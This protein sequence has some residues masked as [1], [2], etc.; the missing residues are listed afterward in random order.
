MSG[1]RQNGQARL[2][3]AL[4]GSTI[5]TM[6]FGCT[7]YTVPWA[8]WAD[9][10]GLLWLHPD[11]TTETAPHGT[12]SMRLELREDG[13]HVWPVKG[14]AYRPQAEPGYV[15]TPSRPF[16]PVAVLEDER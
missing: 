6:D 8:M 2:P 10:E 15:G 16:I 5:A 1:D 9:A 11:Y 12:L 7:Y 4:M 14:H 3:V 13:Y